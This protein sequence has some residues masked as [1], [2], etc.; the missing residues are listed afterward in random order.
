M[1]KG[2]ITEK[3]RQT[4][5]GVLQAALRL[6]QQKGFD[7]TTMR[8]IAREAS[9]SVGAAYYYFRTK[10]ELVLAFYEQIQHETTGEVDSIVAASPD[11][12]TR[13]ERLIRFKF[14]QLASY[15]SLAGVLVR[16]AADP[17]NPLS[18][19]SSETKHIRD[20]AIALFDAIARGSNLKA[21][22]QLEPYLARLFW[23]YLMGL[24]FFWI[25][26]DSE[27]QQRTEKLLQHATL[28]IMRL[29]KLS[30]LPLM[31]PVNQSVVT[32]L[33]IIEGNEQATR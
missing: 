19:F 20:E 21:A 26:D 5:E 17:K 1:K 28:I 22:K 12:R 3:A 31:R 8:D 29:I 23:F 7:E 4:R 2:Q 30:T 32:L 11:F 27:N 10:D 14:Q 16:N 18:P 25:H 24:L 9:L 33:R 15:R 6:F 13:L